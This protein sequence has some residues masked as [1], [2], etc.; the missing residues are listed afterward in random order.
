MSTVTPA[1]DLFP[2]APRPAEPADGAQGT[3]RTYQ[4]TTMITAAV[5]RA[6]GWAML[7][8]DKNPDNPNP[9]RD[10]RIFRMAVPADVADPHQFA[11]DLKAN[12]IHV[13]P[14][15]FNEAMRDLKEMMNY[16][17]GK[18]PAVAQYAGPGC[19]SRCE[20]GA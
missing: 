10:E 7:S 18:R 8:L 12:R 20:G 6:A 3:V 11:K 14:F 17:L 1:T 19:W 4:T 13:S 2:P 15:H 9:A 16:G 5:M